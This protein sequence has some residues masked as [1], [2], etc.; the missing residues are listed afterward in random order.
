MITSQTLLVPF[1]DEARTALKFLIKEAVKEELATYTPP[2]P[3]EKLPEYLTRRETANLFRISLMTL[4]EWDK[5]R[6]IPQKVTV[7]GRVRYRRDEVLATLE[8]ANK[9][10]HKRASGGAK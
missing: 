7:N 3:K 1:D 9:F 2:V 5:K 10:K 8:N 6:L 4:Y